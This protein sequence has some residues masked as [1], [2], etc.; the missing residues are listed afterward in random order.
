MADAAAE[1]VAAKLQV[2]ATCLALLER[3]A[4]KTMDEDVGPKEW[5]RVK[6]EFMAIGV[7]AGVDFAATM[8]HVGEI[9]AGVIY[10]PAM[11]TSND[12]Q[13]APQHDM[14]AMRQHCCCKS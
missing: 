4:I 7:S 3:R 13:A 11:V 10:D 2:A 8:D 6:R 14:P 9:P 1:L 12:I 5:A